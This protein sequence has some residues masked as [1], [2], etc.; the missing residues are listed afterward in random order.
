MM[1][2]EI[3]L[4][5]GKSF[6]YNETAVFDDEEAGF[7]VLMW[8]TVSGGRLNGGWG[9]GVSKYRIDEISHAAWDWADVDHIEIRPNEKEPKEET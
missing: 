9:S 7:A 5:N 4:E 2:V 1:T 3:F 6:Q 8:G